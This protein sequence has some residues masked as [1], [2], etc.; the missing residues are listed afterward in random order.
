MG[1]E[2]EADCPAPPHLTPPPP[3]PP[4][5]ASFPQFP[6]SGS[7][8]HP[9]IQLSCSFQMIL[10]K[11]SAWQVQGTVLSSKSMRS[12]QEHGLSSHSHRRQHGFCAA[13]RLTK[14]AGQMEDATLVSHHTP[15]Q[16]MCTSLAV[17]CLQFELCITL[18]ELPP[19]VLVVVCIWNGG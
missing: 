15:A 17:G 9:I 4:H 19:S 6:W 11:Q 18:S 3:P 13:E 1:A 10:S 12:Y 16:S 5:P 2:T 7:C 14:S 8:S